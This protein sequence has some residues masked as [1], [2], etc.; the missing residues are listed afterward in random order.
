MA[1]P[2]PPLYRVA[3]PVATMAVPPA[4]AA[5]LATAVSAPVAPVAMAGPAVA[6]LIPSIAAIEVQPTVG[7][8]VPV[9]LGN[10]GTVPGATY[11]RY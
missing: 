5:P 10:I 1:S 8:M 4:V 11:R 3:A 9:P 6:A 7:Y 2:Q